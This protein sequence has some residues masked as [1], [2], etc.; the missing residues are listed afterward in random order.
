MK[1]VYTL[2]SYLTFPFLLRTENFGPFFSSPGWLLMFI[3]ILFTGNVA[4]MNVSGPNN[5][6]FIRMSRVM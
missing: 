6:D 3:A 1:Y 2:G 4:V 5:F